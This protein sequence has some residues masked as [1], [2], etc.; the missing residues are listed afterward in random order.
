VLLTTGV[1]AAPFFRSSKILQNY[2]PGNRVR[3][4]EKFSVEN[5]RERSGDENRAAKCRINSVEIRQNSS[6][7]MP[8]IFLYVY[9]PQYLAYFFKFSLKVSGT[10]SS[11]KHL[12]LLSCNFYLNN[13]SHYAH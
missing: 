4:I 1:A 9:K 13:L 12:N 6:S 3:S 11:I 7:K 8:Q 2:W 10:L 5:Q